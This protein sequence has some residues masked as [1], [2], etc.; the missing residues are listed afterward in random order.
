MYLC[1]DEVERT[2]RHSISVSTLC[3]VASSLSL[4]F[5]MQYGIEHI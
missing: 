2:V 4:Y 5:D 3:V 1:L